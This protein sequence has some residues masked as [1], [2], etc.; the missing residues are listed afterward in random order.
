MKKRKTQVFLTGATGVMGMAGLKEL[1]RYPDRYEVTVLARDSKR[2]RKKLKKFEQ[3]GVKTIWGDLLDENSLRKGIEGADIVLHVG[4]MVSPVADLYPEKTMKVNVGSMRLI[5]RIIK[6]IEEEEIDRNIK[7]VYIGSVA[8]YG[9]K[10]PPHHWGK[11]SDRLE[12]AKLDVYAKS[13]IEAEEELRKAGLRKWVSIRQTSI[14]HSGL[15]KKANNPVAFHTPING[16]LEWITTEDSGR[17]LERVCREEVPESFW[18]KS[19][20]AGGGEPF[21][22]TN[23]EFERR[24]LKAMGCPPPEKVFEPNWFA[25]DNFHGMWFEDSDELD[26]IL[27]YREPD[28]FPE[29]LERIRKEL[30]F[31][32]KLAPLAPAFLIKAFMKRVALKPG[33]GPLHWIKTGDEER[34]RYSWGSLEKYREIPGW[35]DFK[36]IKIERRTPQTPKNH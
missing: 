35:K 2:N 24:L 22:L 5:A 9:P 20:N 21:R 4:G 17:L 36:E 31:Y 10:M 34:I 3:L 28:T 6:E 8:Q 12:G 11:A 15:L 26:S 27:H 33:L 16:V 19:Y 32:F 1:C 14:L 13:K 30:P 18:G 7:T 25:G 29:A 23:I